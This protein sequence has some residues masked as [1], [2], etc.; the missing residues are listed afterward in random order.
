[1]PA[2]LELLNDPALLGIDI[3]RWAKYRWSM[4]EQENA[5]RLHTIIKDVSPRQPGFNFPRLAWVK[6]SRLRTGVGLFCLETCK[7]MGMAS[8]SVA[9]RSRQLNTNNILPHLSPSKGSHALSDIDK[10]LMTWLIEICP[11]V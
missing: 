5:S 4:D 1:M 6:L 11:A 3:A 9:Q 8:A 7:W 2:A 10:S